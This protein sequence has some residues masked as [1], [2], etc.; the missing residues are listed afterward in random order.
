MVEQNGNSN[1]QNVGKHVS[2]L[3]QQ[4]G[5]TIVGFSHATSISLNHARVIKNGKSSITLKTA[6]K[7]AR[8]FSIEAG[9]LFLA[10]PILLEDPLSIPQIINFYKENS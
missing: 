3:L 8:F 2:S 4:S 10:D 1:A 6:E 9:L 5:I 7:I